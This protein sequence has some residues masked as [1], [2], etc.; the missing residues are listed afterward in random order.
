MICF[1]KYDSV[2]DDL[3]KYKCLSCN[4]DN[5]NITNNDINKLI[6]LLRKSVNL[7]DYMDKW[8][9]FNETTLSEKKSSIET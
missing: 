3:V 8:E 1:L 5:S 2:K 9:K 4:K 7:Y 6:L